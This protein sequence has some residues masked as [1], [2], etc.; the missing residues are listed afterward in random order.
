MFH[1]EQQVIT[2][3]APHA[4]PGTDKRSDAV[5]LVGYLA[6]SVSNDFRRLHKNLGSELY[7]E[8]PVKDI[9]DRSPVAGEGD[10]ADGQSMIWVSPD[11]TLAR[12]EA[13]LASSFATPAGPGARYEWPRP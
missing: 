11:A 9:V 8:I 6:D 12:Y 2:N 4:G 5:A 13:V 7:L 10:R 3:I 1:A